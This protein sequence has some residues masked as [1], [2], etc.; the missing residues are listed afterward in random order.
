MPAS[1]ILTSASSN[2]PVAT[3]AA[4]ESWFRVHERL[5]IIVLAIAA[6]V[7]VGNKILNNQATHDKAVSDAAV[8]QLNDTKAQNAA[9]LA[10]VQQ[11]SQQYQQL[12]VK[13]GVQNAQLAASIQTRTVVL[14][15]Q[16]KTDATLPL[17]DLGARWAQLASIKPA[18]ITATAAGITVTPVG[19]LETTQVLEQVPALQANVRDLQQ[20]SDNDTKELSSA[21]DLITGLNAQVSGL[22]TQAVEA[23][24]TCKSEIATVKATARRGKLKAFLYGLGIGA[25]VTAG[26]VIHA[27]L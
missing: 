6:L 7:F 15:Q 2:A 12:I 25:G 18:D 14:Q 5:I 4:S 21:N 22:Q 9:I 16:V 19:A 3:V 23:D 13:L 17:P 26:L 24:K 1:P 20:T 27:L 11:Q 10:Q 8:Q